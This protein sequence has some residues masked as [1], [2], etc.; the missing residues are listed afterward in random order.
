MTVGVPTDFA[1][2]I[3]PC[4]SRLADDLQLMALL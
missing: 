4:L 2:L 1:R 3:T